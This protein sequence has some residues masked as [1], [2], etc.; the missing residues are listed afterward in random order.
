MDDD[1][2]LGN[3]FYKK[4]PIKLEEV[5]K[6]L[7][8][9]RQ[10]L[11]LAEGVPRDNECSMI[12]NGMNVN[13]F[14]EKTDTASSRNEYAETAFSKPSSTQHSITTDTIVT[15]IKHFADVEQPQHESSFFI[16]SQN[17]Q[18]EDPDDYPHPFSTQPH[19]FSTER[20]VGHKS[21]QVSPHLQV[22]ILHFTLVSVATAGYYFPYTDRKL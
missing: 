5:G 16:E 4:S 15:T 2:S 17:I 19:P 13:G 9:H 11:V 8:H 14:S 12:D 21:Q 1:G 7:S 3:E 10:K 20:Y 22:Y 18:R 6:L